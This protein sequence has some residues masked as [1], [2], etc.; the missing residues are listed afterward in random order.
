LAEERIEPR[1][2]FIGRESVP[3]E[4]EEERPQVRFKSGFSIGT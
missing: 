2:K 1:E 4:L 3:L